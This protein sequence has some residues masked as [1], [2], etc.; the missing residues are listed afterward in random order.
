MIKIRFAG[1]LFLSMMSLDINA[2][3]FNYY[4]GNIHAHSSYSDGNKDSATSLLTRP[5]QD[6]N[7]A[8]ASQHIDFYGISEHNHFYAGMTNPA[9]YHKGLADADSVT[10][11]GTFVAMYGM[12]WGIIAGGGHVIVYGYDSLLG[13]DT[14]DYDVYVAQNNYHGLW[15]KINEK[16]SSF[17]Y[18]AHPAA[19]DYSNL[20]SSNVDLLA[21]N[22]IVGMAMHSGPA[23]S[24]DST[25][26]DPDVGN[27][28]ARYNDALK[29]GYHLGVGLDHDSHYTVFGRQTPGRLVVLADSL[30]RDDIMTAFHKM[31]FYSSDDWNVK[32]NFTIANQPMGSIF[33]QTGS[34]TITVSVTDPDTLETISSIK[35]YSGT[36]G[37]GTTATL[38]NT[39]NN[40][41][42]LSYSHTIANNA[43]CY[44]YLKITQT[45]GDIIWT[46]P[47]WYTRSDSVTSTPPV[48]GFTPSA[49]TICLG[50]Q[51]IFNDNSTNGA[52]DWSWSLPNVLPDTSV[53]QNVIASFSAPGTYPVSLTVSN[54]FGTSAIFTKTV[55][56]QVCTGVKEISK[57][58]IKLFPNPTGQNLTIDAG[59]LEGAKTVEIVDGAGKLVLTKTNSDKIF[60]IDLSSFDDGNYFVNL[61]IN[62]KI[63]TSQKLIL[64]KK[65]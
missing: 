37:S 32:V 35:I 5:I 18:L 42:T 49:D 45:D 33:E 22:A 8:K 48:A 13:W 58:L 11:N 34:P 29:R 41:A 64:V 38:L 56:V 55:T 52:T 1:L 2:Q 7:Y 62:N 43:T 46:S 59:L 27:Y 3:T 30:T 61:K 24:V 4:F 14:N 20:F 40:S 12:E 17:A 6:F 15:Q 25:Y 54:S 19:T 28:L 9:N 57:E 44:Y 51:I 65:K 53:N 50:Q 26:S 36:P 63:Y 21:D 10:V 39:A 47:I 31:R 60:N 16:I 23:F